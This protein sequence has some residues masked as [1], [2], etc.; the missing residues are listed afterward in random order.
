MRRGNFLQPGSIHKCALQ[1][2][3]NEDVTRTRDDQ[4]EQVKAILK[5]FVLDG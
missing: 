4:C 5:Q 2:R 3:C 1:R